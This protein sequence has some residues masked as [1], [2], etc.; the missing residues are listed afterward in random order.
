MKKYCMIFFFLFFGG[1]EIYSQVS[2][3][4]LL[5]HLSDKKKTGHITVYNTST[6]TLECLLSNNFGYPTAD[7]SGNVYIKMCD[8]IPANEPSA[9]E[10]IKLYPK[11][12]FLSPNASQVI[13]VLAKPPD[14]ISVGE[15]WSRPSIETKKKLSSPTNDLKS[16]ELRASFGSELKMFLSVNYRSGKVGVNIDP[17]ILN[18]FSDGNNLNLLLLLEPMGN[19]AFLGK[20]ETRLIEKNEVFYKDD[21]DIAVYHNLKRRITIPLE[22]IN[23]KSFQIEVEINTNRYDDGADILKIDPIILRQNIVLE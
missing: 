20:I 7:D 9:K 11:N 10:W 4:P 8:T 3:S 23:R 2:V 16:N 19:A 17:T 5:L 12:F 14:K 21:V 1:K 18:C 15:Y 22:K 6:D 13:R